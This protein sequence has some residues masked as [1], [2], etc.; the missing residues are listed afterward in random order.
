MKNLLFLLFILLPLL[1]FGQADLLQKAQGKYYYKQKVYQEDELSVIYKAHQE[2][3]DLYISGLNKKKLAK[4]Y[5]WIA[6]AFFVGGIAGTASDRIDNKVFG[7]LSYL[8][9]ITFG[10]MTISPRIKGKYRLNKAMST[11]NHEMIRRHGYNE[12]TSLSIQLN[13]NG[14]ALLYA[15]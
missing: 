4:T 14:I 3:L 5:T 1:S 2:S 9:G 6:A 13:Q 7:G 12:E 8:C 10:L 11:F 15:F